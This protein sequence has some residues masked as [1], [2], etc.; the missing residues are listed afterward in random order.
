M[1][2]WKEREHE[3]V[4]TQALNDPNFLEDLRVCGLLKFFLTPGMWA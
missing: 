4:D 2:D 3:D 1:V